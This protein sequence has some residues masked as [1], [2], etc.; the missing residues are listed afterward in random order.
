MSEQT[1]T[2]SC[3]CG[4]VRY[5]A[6]PP[7]FAFQY[8][9]CTR[10]RKASGTAHATNLFVKTAQFHWVA[11]EDNVQ[12]FD[13][14]TAKYW[15][16]TFCKTCGSSTPWL[17]RTGKAV[18]IPAGTLDDDPGMAPERNI[19]FASRASWYAHAADLETFD[20]SPPRS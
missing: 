13:L 8:C 5:A 9:H 10:C 4:A 7:F 2:G 16:H 1:I 14:P 6:T 11:G 18:I 17:S 20:E 3:V 15:S 12:R 19:F